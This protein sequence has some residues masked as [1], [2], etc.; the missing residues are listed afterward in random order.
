MPGD[1]KE[2]RE[3]AKQCLKLA[4]ETPS[5]LAKAQFEDLA[6]TWSRLATDIERTKA[7]LAQWGPSDDS[8]DKAGA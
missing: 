1:P 2:C 6:Q 8:W 5:P 3:H 7:F 4:C